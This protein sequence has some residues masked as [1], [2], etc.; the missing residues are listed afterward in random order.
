MIKY[1][2]DCCNDEIEDRTFKFKYLCHL[3][4]SDRALGYWKGDQPFSG[5][6]ICKDLC[7][8]C[9]NKIFGVAVSKFM[10][11]KNDK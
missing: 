8:K 7:L 3:D 4:S 6:E 10:E 2:C 11:L 5:R 1:F 9:Y